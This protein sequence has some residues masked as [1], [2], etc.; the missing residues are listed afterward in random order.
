ML[1]VSLTL[2]MKQ[3]QSWIC[4]FLL[5]EV[6]DKHTHKKQTPLPRHKTNIVLKDSVFRLLGFQLY[7]Y[8]V[9]E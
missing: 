8:V 2:S 4:F 6:Q 7:G 1:Q 9:I 3:E 5:G